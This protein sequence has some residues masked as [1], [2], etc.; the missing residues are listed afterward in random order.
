[1]SRLV[2]ATLLASTL[3]SVSARADSFDHYTNPLLAKLVESKAAEKIAQ[4][5]PEVM[6]DH[7]RVLPGIT[8]TFIVVKTN[9]G[10]WVKAL[11]L[12]ARHKT[13][14]DAS[15]PIGLLERFV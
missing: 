7:A 13:G 5:T 1:M 10:R 3:I 14:A 6:I 2:I 9:E 15:V 11:I 8:S 12:P 4:L